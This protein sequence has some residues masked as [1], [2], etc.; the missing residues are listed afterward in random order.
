MR[1]TE[2]VEFMYNAANEFKCESCPENRGFSAWGGNFPCGQQNCWVTCHVAQ[3]CEE[4]E[5][6]YVI[7]RKTI[8][9]AVFPENSKEVEMEYE[10]EEFYDFM[11]EIDAYYDV[12]MDMWYSPDYRIGYTIVG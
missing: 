4:D 3:H 6:D 12:E 8:F 10:L 11:D 1:T 7:I 2:Y 9:D 5:G